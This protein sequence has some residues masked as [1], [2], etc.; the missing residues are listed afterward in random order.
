MG[1][2]IFGADFDCQT[3]LVRKPEL[4]GIFNEPNPLFRELPEGRFGT[5]MFGFPR[6]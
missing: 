2:A 6:R 3:D 4:A 5:R 1:R